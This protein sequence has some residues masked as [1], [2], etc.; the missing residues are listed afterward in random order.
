MTIDPNDLFTRLVTFTESVADYLSGRWTLYQLLLIALC[1]L[2]ALL[3]SRRIEPAL[4]DRAR[5]IHGN[6]DILR[7][8]VALLRR[9]EWVLFLILLWFLRAILLESTWPSR[10]YLISVAITLAFAWLVTA[11]LT[12]A[13][14]NRTLAR[15]IAILA[16]AYIAVDILDLKHGVT[17]FLDS[18]AL[19]LGSIRISLLL[20]LNTVVVTA[21]LLW[22]ASIAGRIAENQVQRLED[23]SPS[24]RVLTGKIIRIG[25][26]AAAIVIAVTS[27]GIDL[28]A[29][30]LLSGAI[31]VGLGFGLQK[32]VSN[33]VSGII[34]LG[35]KSIKPGD[36][37]ELG[38]TFGWI[39]ELRARYVSVITRDGREYLIPNEDFITQQVVNWSYSDSFVRLDVDFGVSYHS[40][41]HE[42]IRI[43]VETTSK[44]D[45]IVTSK[46]PVCWM[47]AFGSS[48]LDF[49]LRFWI[50]D[51]KAGLTNIR[52][53]VLLALWDAFKKADISIPFPHREII[54]KTPVDIRTASDRGKDQN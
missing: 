31:G 12:R 24:V 30:T 32:V 8:L 38:E 35:D 47:T 2:V 16:F 51:P 9:S 46:P 36:T 54:M 4:V 26:V 19:Q 23:L 45:R 40:D 22:F 3:L 21:L 1:F 15:V 7:V 37:I 49:K 42:V 41:P 34:I 28:T 50:E 13:I 48:S 53:Q 11:V 39:Q 10:T 18:L 6:P 5:T 52:G 20:V 44:V 33:F 17:T 29:F 43:A 25:L 27:T 14:R